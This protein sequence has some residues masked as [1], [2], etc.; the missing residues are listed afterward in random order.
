MVPSMS[1]KGDCWDNA[2]MERFFRSLK[3]EALSGCRFTTRRAARAEV[4]DYITVY[5]VHRLHSAIG[6]LSPMQYEKE[7]LLKVA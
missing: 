1:R 7:Q 4:L 2:P 5:N 3:S 6:Y